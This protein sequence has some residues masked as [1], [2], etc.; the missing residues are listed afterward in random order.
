MTEQQKW[1]P[2]DSNLQSPAPQANATM[3]H[4]RQGTIRQRDNGHWTVGQQDKGQ[5]DSEQCDHG[6]IGQVTMGK[7]R[8][9]DNGQSDDCQGY[10]GQ[11]HNMGRWGS[12]RW[13]NEQ[14]DNGTLGR[15]TMGQRDKETMG[16]WTIGGDRV[17]SAL[18]F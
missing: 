6:V 10:N 2:E 7:L 15:W 5:W 9:L 13:D 14:W 11:R 12:G 17:P 8:H 4:W 3:G 1:T 16:Q 18:H